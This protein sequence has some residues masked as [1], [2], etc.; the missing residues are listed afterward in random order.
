MEFL[1]AILLG[2][3]QGLT[4]FLPISSSGHLVLFS[5]LL[6]FHDQGVVFGVFLHLGTLV[7]VLLVFYKDVWEMVKAPF[8]MLAGNREQKVK[9]AFLWDLYIILATLPTVF[10]GLFFKDNVE[11]LFTN[12]LVVYMMLLITGIIMI[13]SQF[14]PRKTGE[15]TAARSWWVGCAQACAVLPGLS[16]SGS[17]IFVGMLLGGERQ[18]VARFSFIMSIPAILGAVVLQV[19]SFVDHPPAAEAVL[20]IIAGTAASVVSGYLAIKLLFDI[21]KKNRLQ[22]FG[23]YCL[24][25]STAGFAHHFITAM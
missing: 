19:S 18:T 12:V 17:T 3:I 7:A 11:Q 10:I 4:E 23:Y 20:N 8:Q 24:V 13:C 25:I 21:V 6:D 22:W 16:R 15:M 2:I 14:V 5:K 9:N 1:K